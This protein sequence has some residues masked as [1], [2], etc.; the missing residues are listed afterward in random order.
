M[1]SE[2]EEV[3]I[4]ET[5]PNF[6]RLMT[7]HDYTPEKIFHDGDDVYEIDP[8]Y[9]EDYDTFDSDGWAIKK[10]VA[11]FDKENEFKQLYKK[12][13]SLRKDGKTLSENDA[14][15]LED[16]HNILAV[17]VKKQKR[18]ELALQA[19]AHNYLLLSKKDQ[20]RLAKLYE[21]TIP[22]PVLSDTRNEGYERELI[23]QTEK[24]ETIKN[25]SMLN[26]SYFKRFATYP[27]LPRQ[28]AT[29]KHIYGGHR[30][31]P[32][33]NLNVKVINPADYYNLLGQVFSY[34]TYKNQPKLYDK[35]MAESDTEAS[36]KK[37]KAEKHYG[38]L[39]KHRK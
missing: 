3:I 24:S 8:V 29:A 5:E 25:L 35:L 4:G 39:V 19:L 7:Y 28:W 10:R 11:Y 14:R 33:N 37:R 21:E 9:M 34:R 17:E 26:K 13:L 16:L 20:Q 18:A 32:L 22:Q 6:R 2:E 31:V 30:T 38:A 36:N 12:Y 23:R 27:R 15:R 1:S